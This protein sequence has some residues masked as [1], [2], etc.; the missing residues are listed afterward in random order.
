M[1]T[2]IIIENRELTIDTDVNGNTVFVDVGNVSITLD[3]KKLKL[4]TE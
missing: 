1:Q 4:I 2:K 3:L